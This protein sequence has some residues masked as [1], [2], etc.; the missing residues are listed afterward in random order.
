MEPRPVAL[1][2]STFGRNNTAD[3]A[4]IDWAAIERDY[5]GGAMSLRDM[6]HKHGCSHSAIANCAGRHGWKRNSS[7]SKV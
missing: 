7:I 1:G 2:E 4:Q 5:R 3:R 6:A